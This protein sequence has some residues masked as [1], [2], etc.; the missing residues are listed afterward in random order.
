MKSLLKNVT[1][2]SLTL[3]H[4]S[5]RYAGW[6]DGDC[7]W[8]IS[9]GGAGFDLIP[10]GLDVGRLRDGLIV[11]PTPVWLFER[12]LWRALVCRGWVALVSDVSR[13]VGIYADVC[14]GIGCGDLGWFRGRCFSSARGIRREQ[15]LRV[16]HKNAG[17]A[18]F[19]AWWEWWF[20]GWSHFSSPY[21]R[22][23]WR[24]RYSPYWPSSVFS[25]PPFLYF[26]T[27]QAQIEAPPDKKKGQLED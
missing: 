25:S 13:I 8:S 22:L 20:C 7:G 18:M 17:I 3:G 9:P 2:W 21:S 14:L 6:F 24:T 23:G 27:G 11:N 16:T 10:S 1:L 12:Y 15:S 4:F 26:L 19:T 5:V